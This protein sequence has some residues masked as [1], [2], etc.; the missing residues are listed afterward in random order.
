MLKRMNAPVNAP[1]RLL[2][3]VSHA[4]EVYKLWQSQENN[5]PKHL[6]YTLREKIDLLFLNLLEDL[7]I[8]GY[9]RKDEKLPTILSALVKVDLLKFFLRLSWEL[10]NLDNKSYL[11]ISEKIEELGRMVGGWKKGLETKLPRL[12]SEGELG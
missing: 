12:E 8:A 11:N 7:F 3:V 9:Q 5:F 6:K 1:P 10:R 2:P 4:I